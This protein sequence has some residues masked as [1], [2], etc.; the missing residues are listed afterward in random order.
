MSKI[1]GDLDVDYFGALK[2]GFLT[3][4][5]EGSWLEGRKARWFVL[6]TDRIDYFDSSPTFDAAMTQFNVERCTV[7]A[8]P[9]IYMFRF[10]SAIGSAREIKVKDRTL[11]E[12]WMTAMKSQSGIKLVLCDE[13]VDNSQLAIVVLG[14]SETPSS[15]SDQ[16]Q[17][18]VEGH[19]ILTDEKGAQYASFVIRITSGNDASVVLRRYSEIRS[20]YM[21][22]RTIFPHEQVPRLPRTNLWN[23]LDPLYLKQKG[24]HLQG[25]LQQLVT[26]CK[27]N[28]GYPVLLKFLSD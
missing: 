4:K 16:L 27:D 12:D 17:I 1:P 9:K 18:R 24:V 25:F 2:V 22:L 14:D 10:V 13:L 23:K 15:S 21:K 26:L 5:G 11:F 7:Y 19:Q 6:H 3:K 8:Y 28:R 20:L